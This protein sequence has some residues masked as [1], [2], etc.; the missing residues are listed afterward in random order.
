MKTFEC[1]DCGETFEE[2]SRP[3]GHHEHACKCGTFLQ[4]DQGQVI[5]EKATLRVTRLCH[6]ATQTV[7]GPARKSQEK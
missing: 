2:Q 7:C 5:G 3:D 1:L 4:W 6:V